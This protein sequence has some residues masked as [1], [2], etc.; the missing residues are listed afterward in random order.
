MA[1]GRQN[2][3]ICDDVLRPYPPEEM[4]AWK[5]LNTV[6]NDLCEPIREEVCEPA[7]QAGLF[8]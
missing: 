6:G 4:K 2:R 5:V 1:R 8:G 7:S 3:H